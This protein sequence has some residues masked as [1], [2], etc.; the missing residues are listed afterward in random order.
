M[1]NHLPVWVLLAVIWLA[2]S[3][4]T[5]TAADAPADRPNILFAFAD[6]WGLHAGAYGTQSVRTPTFDHVAEQG[7][8]FDRAFVAA[9]SCTAARGSVLTGQFPWRLGPGANLHSTLPAELAVYPD[10]LEEAGYFVGHARKGWGPGDVDASERERNPA[11]PGFADFQ[12]FLD[13]RPDD[14]PFCFWF[15]SQD[16]HRPY[17]DD[18]RN[19]EQIDPAAVQVPRELPDV[20]AVR[21][22]IAAYYAE[23]QRFD[24]EVGQLIDTLDEI[25]ELENTV[26][27]ISSDHGWPF[28]RGKSNLYDAGTHVPLAIVWPQQMADGPGGRVVTDFIQLSDLAPTFL[29]AAGVEPPAGMTGRSL[30][31]ILSSGREGRVQA[32]RSYA[33]LAKERHHGQARADGSGYPMRGIRTEDYLYIRNYKP[34]RW[35]QGDP[36]V[37][38]SQGIFSDTDAGASKQYLID[39]ANDPQVLPLFRLT[40]DKRPAEEL[41]DLREDPHQLDN[42]ADEPAYEAI[43]DHLS[44][45]LMQELAATEDPRITG[46][47]EAFDTYPYR[48]GYGSEA[49]TPP[50]AVRKALSLD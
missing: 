4:P 43:R 37:S 45:I 35:P 20:E 27:V 10:L 49:A 26:I 41:Y 23:V 11:G 33:L 39:H 29:E 19:A 38:S 46:G 17:D 7:V 50:A 9:P 36:D 6:D 40:F 42:V 1:R 5:R 48:V 12:A 18:L 44:G 2:G 32:H 24:R 28:P 30:L 16:P 3:A 13:D 21:Q 47:G 25:G 15:G 22:D 8:R 31:P 34:N 14:A